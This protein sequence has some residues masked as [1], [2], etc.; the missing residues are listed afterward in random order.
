MG[1]EQRLKRRLRRANSA[2]HCNLGR[3]AADSSVNQF[4]GGFRGDWQKAPSGQNCEKK[5]ELL[6]A[7]GVR[8]DAKGMLMDRTRLWDE[9]RV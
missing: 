4:I 1:I 9:F 8:F 2:V 7:E 6:A 5:L 3:K